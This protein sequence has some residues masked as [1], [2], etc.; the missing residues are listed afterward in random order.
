MRG[1]GKGLHS[2]ELYSDDEYNYI[3]FNCV[4]GIPLDM[5]ARALGRTITEINR[6]FERMCYNASAYKY[7]KVY[8]IHPINNKPYTQL[9]GYAK[10][11]IRIQFFDNK[12]LKGLTELSI[13][14][15]I[16]DYTIWNYIEP[17]RKVKRN[18]K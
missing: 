15:G 13:Q 10:K 4:R 6:C 1:K 3:F 9:N 8:D 16:P 14:L 7:Q 18:K 17:L 2:G 11:Y 5:T 12:I